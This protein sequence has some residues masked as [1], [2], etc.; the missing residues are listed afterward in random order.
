MSKTAF[1]GVW[2]AFLTP[3]DSSGAPCEKAIEQLVELFVQQKLGG[4]YV[5]GSTGQWPLLSLEH[6]RKILERVVKTASGRIPVMAHVGAVATEDAVGL[7]RHAASV[8]ADAVSSVT[9]IYYQASADVMFEHYR[10]IGKASELPLFV[11]HLSTVNPVSLEASDYVDRIL[12]LPN[13]AG[14]KITD[15]DLFQFG[16][17]HT[18]SKG[19]LQLFSGADELLCH[20]AFSGAMGAI[21]TFYNLWGPACQTARERTVA[22]DFERTR[23]FMLVF[24]DAIGRVVRSASVWTFLRSAMQLKYKIDV[25]MPR[26]PLGSLD[27]PWAEADV[28]KIV[29]MVDDAV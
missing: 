20:A 2:P 24:Q 4:L 18:H 28:A 17:M 13:I 11:Y 3:L 23:K 29:A 15:R 6:R 9:P 12:A 16:L 25:G 10:Q 8:G 1:G 5:V 19:R 27:K 22:G 26:A 14:M 7:A 21:G